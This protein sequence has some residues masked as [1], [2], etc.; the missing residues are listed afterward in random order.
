MAGGA[1]HKVWAVILDL[2]YML[3]KRLRNAKLD[4]IL[5][6]LIDLQRLIYHL[7]YNAGSNI[8]PMSKP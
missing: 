5:F 2:L 7:S 1:Q 3:Y 6:S 4:L 8:L